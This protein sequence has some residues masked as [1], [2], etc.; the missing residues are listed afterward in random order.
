MGQSFFF[1]GVKVLSEI[2]HNKFSQ[3]KK[4]GYNRN[5]NMYFPLN[6][7]NEKTG[8]G[9][10]RFYVAS[11]YSGKAVIPLSFKCVC[12]YVCVCKLES[13]F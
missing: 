1:G 2:F 12:L 5:V 7:K 9:S 4:K 3:E 11:L 13:Y 10:Y 6:Q 8:S